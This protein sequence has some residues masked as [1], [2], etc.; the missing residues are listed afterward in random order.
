MV[1]AP[2]FFKTSVNTHM[3]PL[4]GV[5]ANISQKKMAEAMVD[6]GSP[7]ILTEGILQLFK[8]AVEQLDAKVASVR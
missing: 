6:G 2:A 3:S 4:G 8:P 7:E 5:E 1:L